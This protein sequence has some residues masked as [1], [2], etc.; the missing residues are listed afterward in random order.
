VPTKLVDDALSGGGGNPKIAPSDDQQKGQTTVPQPAL[1]HVEP[2]HPTPPVPRA[3]VKPKPEVKNIEKPKPIKP[4]N[5]QPKETVKPRPDP[6]PKPDKTA[7]L[8]LKPVTR[9]SIDKKAEA[10]AKAAREA[11]AARQKAA[12]EIASAAQ[13]LKSGFSQGT[14]VDISGPGGETYADY[15]QFVKSVYE[16]AWIVT[17]ELMDDDSTVK[18]SVTI[19]KSGHVVSAHVE[20]HSSNSVLDKSVQRAL[21]KVRFVAPFPPGATDEQ[22]TFLINF[23]LKAKRLLG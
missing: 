16:D 1:P 15:A 20:R 22:R 3:E 6:T 4:P 5:E 7:L 12:K 21:D 2:P 11:A 8:E 10:Q 14:K 17:D 23:N 19:A 18:V 9:P 13:Q